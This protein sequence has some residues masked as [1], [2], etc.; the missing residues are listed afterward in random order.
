MRIASIDILRASTMLLMIWVN[1]FWTLQ[2]VPKWLE[3]ASATEDYLGFSDIIFPL[4]LFIVGLSIPLAIQIRLKKGD[5][6]LEIAKHIGIRSLSL[7]FIGVYMVNWES[8]Y[9]GL[10]GGK[11]LWGLIMATAVCL[12]WMNWK[13][14][15][16]PAKYYRPLQALGWALLIYLAVIYQGG[17]EGGEGMRTKW[18]GILGLIGWAYL[19]NALLFLIF[20]GRL[21]PMFI[22]WLTFTG[23]TILGHSEHAVKLPG[24]L[25]WL[26]VL[27]SGTVPAFTS[28]GIVATLI[29]QK[30]A[31]KGLAKVYG[32]LAILGSLSLLFGLLTRPLWGISKI[33]GTPPWVGV[34]TAIGFFSFLVLYYI[35][36]V[37]GK[38]NWARFMAPAGTATLTCYLIPYFAYPIRDL[39]GIRLPE[40]LNQGF[41][42]LAGSMIFAI[43]VVR[44]TGWFQSKGFSLK[45]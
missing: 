24:S 14:S 15:P 9:S 40:M 43:L 23:L 11:S 5:Q 29:Y 41:I 39:S 33:Q 4:F 44:L 6:P 13:R 34:C 20:K 31:G 17:P 16:L 28:G 32:I 37:K 30:F 45:L 18:W 22:V 1:D 10:P 12:I 38:V 7:L 19:G 21:V 2:G 35:A 27:F 36:D 26:S 3:H 8:A 42:G 25:S